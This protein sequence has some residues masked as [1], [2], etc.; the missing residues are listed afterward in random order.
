MTESMH[1]LVVKLLNGETTILQ[2]LANKNKDAEK[3]YQKYFINIDLDYF[4]EGKGV[5][6]LESN[7]ST[8]DL[9]HNNRIPQKGILLNDGKVYSVVGSKHVTTALW[10][11][12]NNV[13]L[14]D[15]VR[16]FSFLDGLE[17]YPSFESFGKVENMESIEELKDEWREEYENNKAPHSIIGLNRKQMI[18]ISNLARY[19]NN[20]AFASLTKTNCFG[21]YHQSREY[22]D[23][24][25]AKNAKYNKIIAEDVLGYDQEFDSVGDFELF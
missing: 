10:L 7:M 3:I 15:S 22:E 21:F 20:D 16:F 2:E 4:E 9:R 11:R 13:D 18:T 24:I 1:E 6:S 17:F 14:K 5:H 12:L 19:F 23:E 25:D 8:Y